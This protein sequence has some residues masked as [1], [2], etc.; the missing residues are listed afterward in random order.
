MTLGSIAK[1]DVLMCVTSA[2]A[3][4]AGST[5][6]G[7]V[8]PLKPSG[9]LWD[10]TSPRWC[11]ACPHAWRVLDGHCGLI[12][13]PSGSHT[14]A[15]YCNR[16]CQTLP[17]CHPGSFMFS[18]MGV[19]STRPSVGCD[20][21]DGRFV[22]LTQLHCQGLTRGPWQVLCL[23]SCSS[24]IGQKLL[25]SWWRCVLREPWTALCTFGAT[26]RLWSIPSGTCWQMGKFE[27]II[28]ILTFGVRSQAKFWQLV[29]ITLRWLRWLRTFPRLM[30]LHPWRTGP[31]HTM[32]W[33]TPKPRMPPLNEDLFLLICGSGTLLRFR[34]PTLFRGRFNMFSYKLASLPSKPRMPLTRPRKASPAQFQSS[35]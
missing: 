21:L 31:L 24:H 8:R 15:M 11:P 20:T 2:L 4:M 22:V 23:V 30:L 32:A 27:L 34:L 5:A 28:H 17:H 12:R 9:A 10:L 16:P 6:F 25:L 35:A 26:A 7:S 1:L 19:A 18:L 33:W 13:P 3:L 14:I 29:W